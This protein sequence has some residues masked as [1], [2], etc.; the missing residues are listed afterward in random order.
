MPGAFGRRAS[1]SVSDRLRAE[2]AFECE[3]IEEL[4]QKYSRLLCRL[5]GAAPDE[6]EIA[7]VGA[8]LHPFYNGVENLFKRIVIAEEGQLPRGDFWHRDLLESMARPA[9]GA[10]VISGD[11]CDRLSIAPTKVLP[12]VRDSSGPARGPG[13]GPGGRWFKSTRPDQFAYFH[14]PVPEISGRSSATNVCRQLLAW[15]L[16]PLLIG[17]VGADRCLARG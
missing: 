10:T 2:I 8:L 12:C 6:V 5:S 14:K 1:W 16:P 4:L 15:V 13:S 9:T 7:A 17:A 3:Q 11:L